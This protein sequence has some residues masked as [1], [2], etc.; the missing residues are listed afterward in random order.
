MKH[1]LYTRNEILAHLHGAKAYEAEDG[2]IFI[3]KTIDGIET[4]ICHFGTF[5]NTEEADEYI[6]YADEDNFSKYSLEG[7]PMEDVGYAYG[8]D[9]M[10]IK[11]IENPCAKKMAELVYYGN[12]LIGIC[13]FLIMAMSLSEPNTDY[14]M[15]LGSGIGLIMIGISYIGHRIFKRL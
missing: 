12:Y 10:D 8:N 6:C 4:V 9:W 13:G 14:G 3:T 1:I 11:P 15:L 7:M 5:G 2:D